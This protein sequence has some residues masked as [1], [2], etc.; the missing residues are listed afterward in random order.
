MMIFYNINYRTNNLEMSLKATIVPL[1]VG[2]LIGYM[3][4]RNKQKI[5]IINKSLERTVKSRT[6]ELYNTIKKINSQNEN[7]DELNE[8]LKKT[9]IKL[10]ELDKQKD[11]FISV[12]AHE[13]KTPLTS[14]KGFSQLLQNKKLFSETKKRNKYLELINKNTDRLYTLILDLVDSSRIS[15]GKLE[16]NIEKVNVNENLNEI[17]ESM[18]LLI[19]EKGLKSIFKIEKNLPKIS[20]D[21]ERLLQI[22]RNII[23]NAIHYTDKGSIY[24]K[25]YKKNKYVQ[26]E[27]KDTGQGIPKKNQKYIFSRFY[28]VDSSMTRKIGGSGLGLSVCKGLVEMMKGKIWFE[29]TEGKGTT[30]YF[31]IPIE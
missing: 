23:I 5:I 24:V 31:T 15:I 21:K 29:S 8:K 3:V 17:K 10:K 12:A 27:V 16:L 30:F 20:A 7:M 11:E 28:Q 25:A 2:L 4:W 9:N 1:L 13:L 6:H 22:F 26:F 14:I 18:N 19:Q